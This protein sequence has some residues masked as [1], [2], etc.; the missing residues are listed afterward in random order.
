[1]YRPDYDERELLRGTLADQAEY[2]AKALGSGGHRP[3]MEANEV[4]ELSGLGMHPDG[5]GLIA[6]GETSNDNP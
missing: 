5:A 1:L 3:W 4:R 6:A 2:F